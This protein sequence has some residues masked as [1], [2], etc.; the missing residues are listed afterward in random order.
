ML[1]QY[2]VW[3]HKAQGDTKLYFGL[4]SG[5]PENIMP[6]AHFVGGGIKSIK[7][8]KGKQ[9]NISQH[10]LP[11]ISCLSHCVF[12][13]IKHSGTPIVILTK[14]HIAKKCPTLWLPWQ[15][16]LVQCHWCNCL[17]VGSCQPLSQYKVHVS[18]HI[19]IC[20]KSSHFLL[21]IEWWI[22]NLGRSN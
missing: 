11:S 2:A 16:H 20:T 13:V 14:I 12:H 22:R 7:S 17:Q 19:I 3:N 6:L 1:P 9:G 5:Q 15:H 10:I 4:Y 21:Q 8:L 18:T